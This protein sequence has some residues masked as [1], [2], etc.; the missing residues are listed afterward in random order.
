M[1]V[2]GYA[3]VSTTDQDLSLQEAALKAWG[4]DIIHAEKRGGTQLGGCAP[5]SPSSA[6]AGL[7]WKAPYAT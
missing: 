4:C 5:S 6:P 3:R 1:T 7:G 2:I